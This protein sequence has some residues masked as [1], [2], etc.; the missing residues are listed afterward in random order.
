MLNQAQISELETFDA[1]GD[2]VLSAYLDLDPARQHRREYRI[3]FD[4]FVKQA[5]EGVAEASRAEFAQEVARAQD[6][7]ENQEPR[8]KGLALFSCAKRGLWQAHFLPTRVEN[9]FAFEAKPDLA[10][11]LEIL[12]EYERYAVA[13]VDKGKARFFSIF[14]GE[15]EEVDS[16]ED[17]IPKKH[18]QGGPS[19]ARYQRHHEEHVHW[20]LKRVAQHLATLQRR[21]GFDR[22]ILA[23]PSEAISELRRLLPAA[24]AHRVVAVIPAEMFATDAELL[25]KTLEVERHVEREAED[26]VLGELLDEAG[27]GQRAT[28]GVAPTLEALWLGDVLTLVVAEGVHAPGSECTECRRLQPGTIATCSACG[29][30]M[31]P[32]HDLFHRAMSRAREQ[33]GGVEVLHD[34]AAQKLIGAGGGMGALLRYRLAAI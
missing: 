18:D 11:L 10:P 14:V 33:A 31:Q 8:G 27:A 4:D 7:L 32:T 20:H 19:Q 6:W 2:Q 30:A 9:H 15:I 23:G 34:D 26:R 28:C 29:K 3:S 1:N 16:F 12:D 25:K 21:R 24:L 5:R 22:L 13:L 17:V